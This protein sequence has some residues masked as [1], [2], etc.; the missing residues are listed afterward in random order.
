MS[1]IPTAEI[2]YHSLMGL[3]LRNFIINSNRLFNLTPLMAIGEETSSVLGLKGEISATGRKLKFRI[4]VT[5]RLETLGINWGMRLPSI[6]FLALFTISDLLGII[7]GR[8]TGS[9]L[10]SD[11][12]AWIFLA[13]NGVSLE[14]LMFRFLGLNIGDFVLD[15]WL[16]LPITTTQE[17][18]YV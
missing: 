15:S 5:L 8:V 13:D 3:L 12:I 9:E 4:F 10:I 11:R 17:K 1:H 2:S 7:E 16:V 18:D 6:F 14:G